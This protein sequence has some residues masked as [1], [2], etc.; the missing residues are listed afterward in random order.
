ML[1]KSLYAHNKIATING[2]HYPYTA[3]DA[4]RVLSALLRAAQAQAQAHAPHAGLA[5]VAS[6]GRTA[7][8][9][10]SFPLCVLLLFVAALVARHLY[11][12]VFW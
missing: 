3:A 1:C 7:S 6:G 8:Q 2:V 4:S 12:A 5:G 11:S 9:L 10:A